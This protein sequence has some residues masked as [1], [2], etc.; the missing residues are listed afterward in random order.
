[1]KRFQVTA[2][3]VVHIPSRTVSGPSLGTY[4]R[5]AI[6]PDGV[7]EDRLKHLLDSNMIVEVDEEGRPVQ[8]KKAEEGKAAAGAA[9]TPAGPAGGSP[10]E[11]VKANVA[12]A[13]QGPA[14]PGSTVEPV[15]PNARTSKGDLVAYAVANS[16]L[17][18]EDAEA[19]TV[20]DLQAR[21]VKAPEQ[22]PPAE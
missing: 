18:R 11:P 20:K 10:V 6:L 7:P 16:D 13:A 22:Q 8:R 5:D 14:G 1:M 19:M 17:S 4:F 9:K 12:G 2:P 15:K 21:F 3:C